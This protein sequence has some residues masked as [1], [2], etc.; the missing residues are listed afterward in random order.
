[1]AD[2]GDEDEENGEKS[3]PLVVDALAAV[4]GVGFARP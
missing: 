2:D 1:M 4:V 3:A